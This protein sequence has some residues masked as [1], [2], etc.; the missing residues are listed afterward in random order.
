MWHGSVWS[1][2]LFNVYM[3]DVSTL[4]NQCRTGCR[5]AVEPST[6]WCM[7]TSLWSFDLLQLS[8]AN[9]TLNYVS[10]PPLRLQHPSS[11]WWGEI[12]GTSHNR[13]PG[14]WSRHLQ[15]ALY[16]NTYKL[17]CCFWSSLRPQYLSDL[18]TVPTYGSITEKAVFINLRWRTMMVRGCCWRCSDG[19]VP[20]RCSEMLM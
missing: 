16:A 2:C 17:T 18:H 6:L 14:W 12:L 4:L 11:R 10:L 20:V 15:A 9:S 8:G 19:V 1:P 7:L 3:D 13:W 5:L